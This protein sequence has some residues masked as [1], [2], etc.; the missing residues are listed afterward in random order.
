MYW[1]FP[2]DVLVK[3]LACQCRRCKRHGFDPWFGKIP[4]RKKWQPAPVLLPGKFHEQK[5]LAGYSPWG[6]KESNAT[7]HAYAALC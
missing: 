6:H 3:K 1:G 4:W 5:S 7:E 2:G